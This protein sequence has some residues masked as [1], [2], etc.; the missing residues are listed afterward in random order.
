[1]RPYQCNNLNVKFPYFQEISY[2]ELQIK[3]QV[4]YYKKKINLEDIEKRRE[5]L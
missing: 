1:M 2:L 4:M 3:V 5:D